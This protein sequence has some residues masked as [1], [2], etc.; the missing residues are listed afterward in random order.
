MLSSPWWRK[1]TSARELLASNAPPLAGQ[2]AVGSETRQVCSQVRLEWL[3][4]RGCSMRKKWYA[5]SF[6]ASLP[7][8]LLDAKLMRTLLIRFCDGRFRLFLHQVDGLCEAPLRRRKSCTS[9]GVGCCAASY[10]TLCR[11]PVPRPS[12][13][14][15]V[16]FEISSYTYSAIKV[17]QLR[18]TG[19]S[20]KPYKGVRGR[21]TGD[22]EWRW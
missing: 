6:C 20:Y 4:L 21:S 19:E 5:F 18:V 22:V 13:A 1:C 3:G 2:G 14:I 8:W 16:R 17:D 9:L 7:N 11:K 15:R 10:R 12:H